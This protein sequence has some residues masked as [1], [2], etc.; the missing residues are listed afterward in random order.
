M[1]S[2]CLSFIAIIVL[3][4]AL[5]TSG[6]SYYDDYSYKDY[7]S[8]EDS[9]TDISYPATT[10][11]TSSDLT[12]EGK[13]I[14]IGDP[15]TKE[16]KCPKNCK[17]SDGFYLVDCSHRNLIEM[18]KNVPYNTVQLNMSHNLL[19]KL[20]VNDLMNCTELRQ[21]FLQE[22]RIETIVNAE[23]FARLPFLHQINLSR[24]ALKP[25]RGDE[26]SHA[27]SLA[28]L[29]LT[30]NQN[31]VAANVPIIQAP[32]LKTLNLANCS[33]DQFS[34]NTFQ[35][36][37]SLVALYLD[38][39]P[40]DLAK[41]MDAFNALINL[42]TL[43]IPTVNRDEALDLCRNLNAIDIIH[44]S[45]ETHDISCFL[46]TTG[47]TYEESLIPSMKVPT[48]A[49]STSTE[50]TASLANSN[51]T[52]TMNNDTNK[53]TA[54]DQMC[55]IYMIISGLALLL[56]V[57]I[58]MGFCIIGSRRFGT[59]MFDRKRSYRKYYPGN[60]TVDNQNYEAYVKEDLTPI[61][62]SDEFESSS[63]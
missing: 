52:E 16:L 13:V 41:S 25:L 18:P 9:V 61:S 23:N 4:C 60:L 33:I 63:R 28:A 36:L 56:V 31:V 48:D 55:M 24:N 17:C 15:L 62:L 49:P 12:T 20:D 11:Q 59:E 39:N 45:L 14:H 10:I 5:K 37:S 38:N 44:L 7:E 30:N 19:T 58:L 8:S 3:L 46:F 2:L 42:R 47:S 29:L 40:L 34:D 53:G 26:F 43:S 54:Y 27:K 57:A 35:N 50:Q 51:A 6:E 21:I 32:K 22:N 1:K